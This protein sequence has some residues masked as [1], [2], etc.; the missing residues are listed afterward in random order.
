MKKILLIICLFLSFCFTCNAEVKSGSVE[1]KYEYT[2]D[3]KF[4]KT[5][6]K[7]GKA[8][9]LLEDYKMN[10]TSKEDDLDII[11]IP[12]NKKE[13]DW[14]NSILKEKEVDNLYYINAYDKDGNIK[15]KGIYIFKDGKNTKYIRT[16]EEK[17]TSVKYSKDLEITLRDKTF[18]VMEDNIDNSPST[19]DKIIMYV[20]LGII[21]ILGMAIVTKKFIVK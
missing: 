2:K 20:G 3:S 17:I 16:N 6:L 15:S 5:E 9:M 21:A 19:G 18:Y 12:V 7:D 14:L 10:F 13:N 4:Y 8:K 1:A 11:I